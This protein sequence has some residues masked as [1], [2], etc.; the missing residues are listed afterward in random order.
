MC[1]SHLLFEDTLHRLLMS[2]R[3]CGMVRPVGNGKADTASTGPV[4]LTHIP[5]DPVISQRTRM[6]PGCVVGVVFCPCLSIYS[7]SLGVVC[8]VV[9]GKVV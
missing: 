6:H 4:L 2:V 7:V 9:R 8:A 1:A 3:V 5:T